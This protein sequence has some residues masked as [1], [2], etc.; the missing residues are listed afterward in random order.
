MSQMINKLYSGLAV[1]LNKVYISV[2]A[3]QGF[4]T[5]K[6]RPTSG[7]FAPCSLLKCHEVFVLFNYFF[8]IYNE[9]N[10]KL[11]LY[12]YLLDFK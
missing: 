4:Q 3:I 12:S 2:L 9:S 5:I 6:E 10:T 8:V 7:S 1:S 11:Q